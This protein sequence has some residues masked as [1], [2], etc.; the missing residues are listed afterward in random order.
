[1]FLPYHDFINL[2]FIESFEFKLLQEDKN[3][4]AVIRSSTACGCNGGSPDQTLE[5]FG[6]P[7]SSVL[8]IMMS[9]DIVPRAFACDYRMVAGM[10]DSV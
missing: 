9:R 1:M 3:A 7:E 5:A 2:K 8:N 6:L 4:L 10:D